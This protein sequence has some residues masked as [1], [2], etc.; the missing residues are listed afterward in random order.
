[1]YQAVF[2]DLDG[3]LLPI[4]THEFMRGYFGALGSFFAER[5]V[6]AA[7][8]LGG[9]RAGT[10]AMFAYD[11]GKTTNER[12]FWGAFLPYAAESG[13]AGRDWEALFG[14]FYEVAFPRLGDAIEPDPLAAQVVSCLKGK[15]YRLALTTNPLFPPQATAQRLAWTGVDPDAFERVTAYHNSS[16]AKP[17]VEY[18]AENL[19]A[20]GLDGE[21]VLMVG[22]DPVE[23]GAARAC[24][25]D[26]YLVTDHLVERDGADLGATPSGTMGDLLRFA[27]GLPDLRAR[28]R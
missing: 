9:V 16:Y 20:L 28:S 5:G 24:G 18:Y 3:T 12:R 15:G 17:S 8:A 6:D 1:M 27:E 19:A 23:D 25:C 13:N 2:F 11:G 4:D 21:S 10:D 22:N 26:L 14:E 7:W